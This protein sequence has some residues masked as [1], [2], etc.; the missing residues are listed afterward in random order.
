MSQLLYA[1]KSATLI[2]ALLA[3]PAGGS[4]SDAAKKCSSAEA[5]KCEKAC[6]KKDTCSPAEAAKCAADKGGKPAEGG[7]ADKGAKK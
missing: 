7:A 3:V 4:G 2:L 6:C 5:A 1:V